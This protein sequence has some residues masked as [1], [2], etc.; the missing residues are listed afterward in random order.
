M[1]TNLMYLDNTLLDYIE[2]GTLNI[3]FKYDTNTEVLAGMIYGQNNLAK[4]AQYFRNVHR[5]EEVAHAKNGITT[6]GASIVPT[7]YVYFE[8]PEIID[9]CFKNGFFPLIGQLENAG[10]CSK[11]FEDMRLTDEQL[12]KVK[13]YILEKY[14]IDYQMP[15]CP[16]TISG[17]HITNRNKVIVDE[18]TGLS[19]P[20]FWLDEP[21]LEIIGDINEMSYDEI[22]QRILE[23]RASKYEDVCRMRD[24]IE[25]YPF[26]GCGGDARCLLKTYTEVYQ[27]KR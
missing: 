5:L 27:P 16:A 1:F 20:W 13:N 23:Y 6:I 11:Q 25:S 8:L 2:N 14:G 7:S 21:E 9:Y 17:I 3:L 4:I 19:C 15:T 22:V 24:N 10:V 12:M 26:G 18:R